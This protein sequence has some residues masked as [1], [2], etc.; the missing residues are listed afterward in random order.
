MG[1]TIKTLLD[2]YNLKEIDFLK[3]DI[4]GSERE[5]FASSQGWLDSVDAL[6][7]ELHDGIKMGA[8][9]AFYLATSAWKHFEKHG[10]KIF[11]RRL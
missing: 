3:I 2:R 8:S 5:V 6:S 9:R 4:E 10:E 11:A 1:L 7:V